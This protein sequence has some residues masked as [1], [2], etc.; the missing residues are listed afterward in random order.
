MEKGT[1]PEKIKLAKER[2][3]ILKPALDEF[4][5]K[6]PLDRGEVVNKEI[7]TVTN[8]DIRKARLRALRPLATDEELEVDH[9]V[10]TV[11]AHSSDH[12]PDADTASSAKGSESDALL[13]P[14]VKWGGAIIAILCALSLL[15]IY[16]RRSAT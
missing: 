14:V 12:H 8:E 5:F 2:I 1:T 4:G 15:L 10:N 3:R 13:M 7:P 16:K 9:G 6:N 11:P